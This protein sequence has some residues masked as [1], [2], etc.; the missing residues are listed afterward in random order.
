MPNV[1]HAKTRKSSSRPSPGSHPASGTDGETINRLSAS[2]A[3]RVLPPAMVLHGIPGVGKTAFSAHALNPVFIID[4]QEQ[5]IHAL[6][7]SRRADGSRCV[8]EDVMVYPPCESWADLL[9]YLD[10]LHTLDHDRKTVVLDSLTGFEKLCFLHHCK[11][12]FATAEYPDGDW[13]KEGFLSY[14]RGPDNASKTDWPKMIEKLDDLR[15]DR[16]MQVILIAHS[17]TKTQSEPGRP[18]YDQ[19]QPVLDKRILKVTDRWCAMLL[20]MDYHISF[21]HT[22]KPKR[23]AR[24][25]D[26]R[27]IHTIYSGAYMAKSW[28]PLPSIIDMGDSGKEAWDN[29]Q[30][31]LQKVLP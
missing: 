12:N 23:S 17:H 9:A 18:D 14:Y 3:V 21:E 16:Q 25:A 26:K 10:E 28:Y 2:T 4:A 15:T 20:F 27:Y 1:A 13:T 22:G 30:T 19:Y 31:E 29:F 11:Q 5:G 24:N 6:K 8:P 7:Q